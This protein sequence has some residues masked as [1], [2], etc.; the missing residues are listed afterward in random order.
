[1]HAYI[2]VGTRVCVCFT[3]VFAAFICCNNKDVGS[4]KWAIF[5]KGGRYLSWIHKS[6][7]SRCCNRHNWKVALD[8]ETLRLIFYH[9]NKKYKICIYVNGILQWKKYYAIST[10]STFKDRFSFSLVL[11][12]FCCCTVG[13]RSLKFHLRCMLSKQSIFE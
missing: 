13:S 1:M 4:L 10:L 8:S 12:L 3:Y 7:L 11:V 5:E 6:W 9:V 2:T